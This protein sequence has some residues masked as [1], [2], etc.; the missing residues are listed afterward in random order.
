M[1]AVLADSDAWVLARDL[2]A[3]EGARVKGM[4]K[5]DAGSGKSAGALLRAEAMLDVAVTIGRGRER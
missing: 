1:S 5:A 2:C 3:E 4:E